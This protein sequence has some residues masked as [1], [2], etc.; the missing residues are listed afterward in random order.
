MVHFF[1]I[2]DTHYL[3]CVNMPLKGYDLWP[4]FSA[5]FVCQKSLYYVIIADIWQTV[6]D[7]STITSKQN[8]RLPGA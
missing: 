1:H 2:A 6:A 5:T 8:V 7:S 4:I 3:A